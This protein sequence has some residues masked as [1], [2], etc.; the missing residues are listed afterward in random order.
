MVHYTHYDVHNSK[1]RNY[2]GGGG[3][4]GGGTQYRGGPHPHY[5]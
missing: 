5:V 3:G 2:R 1:P 4:G